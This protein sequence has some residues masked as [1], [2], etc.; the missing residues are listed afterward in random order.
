MNFNPRRPWNHVPTPSRTR[1]AGWRALVQHR[2]SAV[3]HLR[4]QRWNWYALVHPLD[5]AVERQAEQPLERKQ[6]V[7]LRYFWLDG[8]FSA[9]SENFYLGFIPLFALAYGASNGEVGWITAVGNLLG[10]LALFPGARLLESIGKRKPIV[11]WSGG[12]IG[13]LVLLLLACLPFLVTAP[14]IAIVAII[15]L[16]G[17]RAFMGNFAN[18]AWTAMVADLV[19]SPMR[20]RYFGSRSFAMGLAALLVAPLA[21]E[22]IRRAN[23][24]NG[25]PFLGYQAIFALAFGFGLVGTLSFG[26]IPEPEMTFPAN[27]QRQRG[28]L[29]RAIRNSPGFLGLVISGFVWNLAIQV[30][31][32]FFNVFL[33]SELGATTATIGILASISSLFALLGQFLFG[34]LL[35]RRGAIWVQKISGLLIPLVPLGWLLVTASWQVG[36]LN[37]L[38]GFLWAGYNLSNFNLLL[39]LTPEAQRPRSVALYQ[40]V[41]FSSAVL[42]PLLGGYLADL[43]SF[44][45]IFGLSGVGRL[46]GILGFLWLV[47]GPALRG[48]KGLPMQSHAER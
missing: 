32:P 25:F 37:A 17:I 14:Q 22:L 40:T 36:F 38:G 24:W 2:I 47:A 21:G 6:L 7:G 30:A 28:D 27:G 33:V 46:F 43:V 34:R 4:P 11:L 31:A 15:V 9:I 42:G 20:G 41:V 39:E 12:G 26:R 5:R 44:K 16:N 10:A 45:F 19:P 3:D 18:P 35:D 1:S 48:G 23:G 8:L 13:R 29:R